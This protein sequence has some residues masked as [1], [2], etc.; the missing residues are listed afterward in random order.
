MKFLAFL[1][2]L[3][4]TTFNQDAIALDIEKFLMPGEV[5]SGH[6]KF[7][8]ECTRCHV[9]MRDTTQKKLCLDCHEKVAG[10]M[11]N[12]SGFHGR[13]PNATKQDCKTCHSDHRGRDASIVWLDKDNFDHRFTDFELSGRHSQVECSACH[14]K[15]ETYREARRDCYSCH[16]EDDAHAGNLGKKCAQCHT[17][18]SWNKSGF[19]HDKTGFKLES[20]HQSVT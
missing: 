1:L 8:A 15:D 18:K 2:L 17:P 12:N 3:L 11:V 5:I 10:D 9:R 6:E 16:S 13:H 14:V 7:E 20:S 4:T 19:D